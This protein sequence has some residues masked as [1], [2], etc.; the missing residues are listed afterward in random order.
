MFVII[1]V[2]KTGKETTLAVPTKAV[3]FDDDRY[4]VVQ[5]EDECHLKLV[6]L[7]PLFQNADSTYFQGG[8]Q[9]GEKILVKNQLLVYNQ[10]KQ[11]KAAN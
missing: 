5:Y 2:Q 3:V 6:H 10:L 1:R 9:V 8:I 7:T 4:F 11:I